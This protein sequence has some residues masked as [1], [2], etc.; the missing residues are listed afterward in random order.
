MSIT[1]LIMITLNIISIILLALAVKEY[2]K[3]IGVIENDE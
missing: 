3:L 2:R 1:D